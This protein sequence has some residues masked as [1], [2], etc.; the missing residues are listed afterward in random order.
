MLV[1]L[2]MNWA[3]ASQRSGL[4]ERSLGFRIQASSK[5]LFHVREKRALNLLL[6]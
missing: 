3:R 6:V 1:Q 5:P 2:L 4:K